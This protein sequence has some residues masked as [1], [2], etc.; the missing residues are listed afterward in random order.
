MNSRGSVDCLKSD[1]AEER[2]ETVI[3]VHR[4]T[5]ERMIVALGTLNPHSEKRLRDVLGKLAIV[6]L[7]LI[8]IRRRCVERA[9]F[10]GD[11]TSQQI[12]ERLCGRDLI[13]N[14]VMESPGALCSSPGSPSGS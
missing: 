8:E 6:R 5:I 2:G 7:D 9:A 13:S 3:V 10:R 1:L 11:H 4:P 12:V 14:P